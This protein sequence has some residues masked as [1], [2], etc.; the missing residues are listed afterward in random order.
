MIRQAYFNISMPVWQ[1]NCDMARIRGNSSAFG[2]TVAIRVQY[3][4]RR[5]VYSI[6]IIFQISPGK[7]VSAAHC[8]RR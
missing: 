1:N 3:R 5:P 7:T 6:L 2:F 4:V 8:S